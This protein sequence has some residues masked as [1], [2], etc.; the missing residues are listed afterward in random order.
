MSAK[1]ALFFL[2]IYIWRKRCCIALRTSQFY[3]TTCIIR[4]SFMSS[5]QSNEVKKIYFITSNKRKLE[6][7]NDML[8]SHPKFEV[9]FFAHSSIFISSLWSLY[10]SLLKIL[11]SVSS[12]RT[13]GHVKCIFFSTD[14]YQGDPEKISIKKCKAA[15]KMVDGPVVSI[16]LCMCDSF[17]S[18]LFSAD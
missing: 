13:I 1:R 5:S 3:Q 8:G 15:Q 6:A 9:S 17:F 10:S 11:I 2:Y 12:T 16:S 18:L 4:R 14:E 7:V